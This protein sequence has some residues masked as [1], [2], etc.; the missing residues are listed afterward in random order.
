MANNKINKNYKQCE[1]CVMDIGDPFIQFD[2]HGF[3]N[4]CTSFLD[5]KEQ[6]VFQG[7][8]STKQLESLVRKIKNSGKNNTYDCLIG[9]SGGVDSSYTAYLCKKLDL[10]P[11]VVHMDNGWNTVESVINIKEVCSK[12]DLDYD[13]YVLDWE[14]FKDLQLAF[15]KSSIVEMEIPTDIAIQGVL[16]KIA[17]ENNIKYIISGGNHA[18]EGIL[19]QSWFYNP[20]DL[21]L[22]KAIHKRFGKVRLRTFP[23]FDWKQE[24][25]YKLVKG[26]KNIYLLN[27]VPY[28]KNDAI[29]T[30]ENILGW[31][32]YGGKHYESKFT[33][34][35]QSYIQPVKFNVD[36]RRATYSTQIC[37]GE[38]TREE[39]LLDLQ[40]S[41]YNT[42]K[43]EED[44][45]YVS[46]KLGISIEQFN[47][48]LEQ[49]PKTYR[50][51]PNDQRMLEFIYNCY[52]KWVE[53][54]K[55]F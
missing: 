24:I 39:A 33:G 32:N 7:E 37:M 52:R 2:E 36:Y 50:D 43:I 8:S 25:Y 21:T 10:R 9:I 26:I 30:L 35:V 48:L 51:Y 42:D 44:K 41:P 16:H 15:M 20:R 4:H 49:P 3:C 13:C 6:L 22:L 11:L 5:K 1:R 31:K 27:Y 45:T 23:A 55:V 40:K 38:I 14:E 53:F 19:P 17:A 28:S 46:K 18:T 34:F 29:E 54:K 12:L 47:T